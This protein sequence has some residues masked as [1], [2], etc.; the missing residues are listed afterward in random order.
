MTIQVIFEDNVKDNCKDILFFAAYTGM[1]IQVV[2]LSMDPFLMPSC[3][4][5]FKVCD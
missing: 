3:A 4:H 1:D 2:H 5:L